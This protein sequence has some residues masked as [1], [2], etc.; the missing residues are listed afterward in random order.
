MC[1]LRSQI[2]PF[3][4]HTSAKKSHPWFF[5]IFVLHPPWCQVP[6]ALVMMSA[7][8]D[9]IT[10]INFDMSSEA[11]LRKCNT[12]R[13][14]SATTESPQR[15]GRLA[16]R[17]EYANAGGGLAKQLRPSSAPSNLTFQTVTG[18]LCLNQFSW[19]N[20]NWSALYSFD[21]TR[22]SSSIANRS[23]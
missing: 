4:I 2:E 10:S 22:N 9:K 6:I 21:T 3:L 17:L 5:C 18:Y 16:S 1:T 13:P 14:A 8:S 12:A 23:A 15:F 20:S 11:L 19:C 7:S